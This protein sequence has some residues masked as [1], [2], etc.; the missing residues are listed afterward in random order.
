M[1]TYECIHLG[2]PVQLMP[3]N[4]PRENKCFAVNS[5]SIRVTFANAPWDS[6]R[7]Q[8]FI[9]TTATNGNSLLAFDVEGNNV[10]TYG[11]N[12]FAAVWFSANQNA[13]IMLEQQIYST[14]SE[15]LTMWD[16]TLLYHS[17]VGIPTQYN[18]SIILGSQMVG[19]WDETTFDNG[20]TATGHMGGF[21]FFCIVLHTI[22][23]L[24]AGFFLENNSTLLGKGN[25]RSGDTLLH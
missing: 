25:E 1:L 6:L 3:C 4:N 22:V 23:M 5:S 2:V 8:C 16:R 24:I 17:T 12:S 20:W 11:G 13:W 18:V 7:I 14:P 10:V 9:T 15:V 19:H 21:A